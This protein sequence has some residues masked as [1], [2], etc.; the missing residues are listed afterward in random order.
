MSMVE[1]L[2]S[3]EGPD[4]TIIATILTKKGFSNKIQLPELPDKSH[5][6]YSFI[7]EVCRVASRHKEADERLLAGLN[8][9]DLLLK[10]QSMAELTLIREQTIRYLEQI[11]F[12]WHQL[13]TDENLDTMNK[14]KS[15]YE[16]VD[17]NFYL[18][19]NFDKHEQMVTWAASRML[20]LGGVQIGSD[21]DMTI[22][23]DDTYLGLLDHARS[24][25]NF[26]DKN[27]RGEL[28]FVMARY[29]QSV[30]TRRSYF[31][32]GRKIPL[33]PGVHKFF[34]FCANKNIP[35]TIMSANFRSIIDGVLSQIQSRNRHSIVHISALTPNS[36]NA[37]DKELVTVQTAITHPKK[38]LWIYAD[39]LSDQG[40]FQGFANGLV[41]C[42]FILKGTELAKEMPNLNIPY[43]LFD[44]FFDNLKT[45]KEI[46]NRATQ[47][48]K[49]T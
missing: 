42:A 32:M 6:N 12:A 49:I 40:C 33:R 22:T 1:A 34:E 7:K 2:T 26:I 16:R 3:L 24:F 43:F 14:I 15:N 29:A 44:N 28:A 9:D 31:L 21:L 23:S 46:F 4:I 8:S 27:G 48:Q 38:S 41:G 47:L 37:S 13:S 25:E 30:V 17:S 11:G 19:S 18:S 36:I 10:S 39:G 20:A 35:I 45:M 5:P